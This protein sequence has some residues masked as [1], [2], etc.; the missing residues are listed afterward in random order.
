MKWLTIIRLTLGGLLLS[1]AL[2]AQAALVNFGEFGDGVVPAFEVPGLLSVAGSGSISFADSAITSTNGGLGVFD[3]LG[4]NSLD[5]GETMTF[6]FTN[7]VE[8]LLLTVHDISPAGNVEYGFNAF[9]GALDLGFFAIDPHTSLSET[10]DL[11]AI[12][13]GAFDSFTLSL[14]SSAPLGLVIEAVE[15]RTAKAPLPATLGLF[16][17][18]LVALG[19]ARR[20]DTLAR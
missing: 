8:A 12:V 7:P 15:F 6:S 14:Q 20:R 4:A 19:C 18:A 17:L 3:Q 11:Y 2:T 5:L 1:G 13:G 16:G 9:A 10:H